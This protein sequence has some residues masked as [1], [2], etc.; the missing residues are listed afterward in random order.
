MVMTVENTVRLHPS[1][2]SA[3]VDGLSKVMSNAIAR[4]EQMVGID[5]LCNTIRRPKATIYKWSMAAKSNGFPVAKGRPLRFY[6]SEVRQ[7][8][9]MQK[10]TR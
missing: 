2:I 3:I 10:T 6:V 7:W 8:L 9:T 1:D 5:D 4:P